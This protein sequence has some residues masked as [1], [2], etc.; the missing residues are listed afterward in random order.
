MLDVALLAGGPMGEA[1]L[2]TTGQTWTVPAGVTRARVVL[3]AQGG[4]GGK[5]GGF[6]T[7]GGGGGGAGSGYDWT[8]TVAPGEV[9]TF[10]I[11]GSTCSLATAN[12]PTGTV[13]GTGG[14]AGTGGEGGGA[15]GLAADGS[16]VTVTGTRFSGG[17]T[18]VGSN[19]GDG[20]PGGAGGSGGGHT[21]FAGAR[22]LGLGGTGGF[23]NFTGQLG[24]AGTAHTCLIRWG[25]L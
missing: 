25:A 14:A 9:F 20:D 13:Q 23:G 5:G 21:G 10:T 2:T 19:G 18:L 17:T 22:Q 8:G 12:S 16:T 7:T 4:N 24:S 11:S 15:G 1:V 3:V 6:V